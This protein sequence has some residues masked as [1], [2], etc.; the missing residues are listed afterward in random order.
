M[1]QEETNGVEG[2]ALFVLRGVMNPKSLEKEL[3]NIRIGNQKIHPNLPKYRK[4][5]I[6][7]LEI[8]IRAINYKVINFVEE[9][10]DNQTVIS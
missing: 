10:K 5:Q 6:F 3:N 4:R 2:L 8:L 9:V 1:Q 7:K